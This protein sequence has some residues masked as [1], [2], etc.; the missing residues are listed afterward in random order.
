MG[1]PPSGRIPWSLALR[2]AAP[3]LAAGAALSALSAWH[4]IFLYL[5]AYNTPHTA[6]EGVPHPLAPLRSVS[7]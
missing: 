2:R 1:D 6:L 3:V 7:D 5:P 4:A